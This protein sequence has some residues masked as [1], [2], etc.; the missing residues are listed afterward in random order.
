MIADGWRRHLG[1]LLAILGDRCLHLAELV[2]P[3]DLPPMDSG[4]ILRRMAELDGV[5]PPATPTVYLTPGAFCAMH[6][7]DHV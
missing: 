4:E 3:L 5:A 2:D 6:W 1:A 7:R